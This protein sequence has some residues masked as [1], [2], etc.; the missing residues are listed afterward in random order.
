MKKLYYMAILPEDKI[1]NEIKEFKL[2]IETNFGLS[3]ALRSPAHITLFPPFHLEEDLVTDLKST[4]ENFHFNP[5]DIVIDSFD[6]FTKKVIYIKV[7]D[8]PPI[9]L[10]VTVYI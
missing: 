1:S 8:H 10:Y 4:I 3:W 9:Q 2:E 5:F 7:E 6:T